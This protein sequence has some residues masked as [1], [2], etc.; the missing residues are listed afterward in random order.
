MWFP[1]RSSPSE[2]A[3]RPSNFAHATLSISN[4]WQLIEGDYI[5]SFFSGVIV[6]SDGILS[7]VVIV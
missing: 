1:T 6:A 2:V 7:G 5:W 3:L 4:R